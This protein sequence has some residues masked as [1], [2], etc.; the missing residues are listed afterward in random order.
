[1]CWFERPHQVAHALWLH[2]VCR[3]GR[4]SDDDARERRYQR[5]GDTSVCRLDI[6]FD[7]W[8]QEWS[9]VL[10]EGLIRHLGRQRR[11]NFVTKQRACRGLHVVHE[12][13]ANPF[14]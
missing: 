4:R 13:V 1:M 7:I 8:S 11:F 14:R 12:G 6:V 10:E 3:R 2:S 5:R 9:N